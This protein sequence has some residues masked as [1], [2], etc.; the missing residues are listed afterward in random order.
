ME[1]NEKQLIERYKEAR[2]YYELTTTDGYSRLSQ[3]LLRFIETAL[4]KAGTSGWETKDAEHDA[5]V[6][7]RAYNAVLALVARKAKRHEALKNQL[8]ALGIKAD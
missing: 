5:L 8:E 4:D 2:D 6:R 7:I 3:A 1:S